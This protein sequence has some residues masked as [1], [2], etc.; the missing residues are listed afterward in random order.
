[1][2]VSDKKHPELMDMFEQIH[3]TLTEADRMTVTIAESL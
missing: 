1:L 2:L 3:L